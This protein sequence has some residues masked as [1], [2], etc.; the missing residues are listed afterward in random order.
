MV[1]RKTF[2]W[3]EVILGI[4]IILVPLV[5]CY[6]VPNTSASY[7]VWLEVAFGVI[8]LIVAALRLMT[9]NPPVK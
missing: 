4:L 9:K 5:W 2:A 3:T 6:I 1:E 7:L 8:V